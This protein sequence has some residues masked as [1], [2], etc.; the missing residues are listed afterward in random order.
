MSEK[1]KPKFE[2]EMKAV[3]KDKRTY[4]TEVFKFEIH[5]MVPNGINPTEQLKARIGEEL[6]RHC[7]HFVFDEE[8]KP[9]EFDGTI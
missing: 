8:S 9:I 5:E 1:Y 2:I 7:R 4:G 3:I 6:E